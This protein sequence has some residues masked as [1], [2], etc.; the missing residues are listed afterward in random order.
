[1][2]FIGFWCI[3]FFHLYAQFYLHRNHYFIHFFRQNKIHCEESSI[4]F[5]AFILYSSNEYLCQLR[6]EFHK[7]FNFGFMNSKLCFFLTT[8][9]ESFYNLNYWL[10]ITY[11]V[12]SSSINISNEIIKTVVSREI[13]HTSKQC[14]AVGDFYGTGIEIWARF[15]PVRQL[16]R[17][18]F[19]CFHGQFFL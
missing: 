11:Y 18:V 9:I 14:T 16:L 13:I 4:H 1:M 2:K 15:G 6:K 5:H 12:K 17:P 7:V 8:K 19:S 3:L 10:S